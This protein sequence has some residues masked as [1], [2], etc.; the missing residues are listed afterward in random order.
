[1]NNTND[2]FWLALQQQQPAEIHVPLY[3]LYYNDLGDPLFYSMDDLPG[4]YI[5]VEPNVF[6][7]GPV[8]VKVVDRKLTIIKTT[9]IH[10]LRPH[11]EGT[12]CHPQDVAVVVD[13]SE[14]H[15]KWSLK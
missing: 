14:P 8:N 3:R 1:M 12:A 6:R 5:D 15:I 9:T 2:N 4:N 10:K 11:T 7:A 13:E